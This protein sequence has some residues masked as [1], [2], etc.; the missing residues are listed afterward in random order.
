MSRHQRWKE[1]VGWKQSREQEQSDHGK[2][3]DEWHLLQCRSDE[4]RFQK[5]QEEV[6]QFRDLAERWKK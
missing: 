1:V 3:T 2:V 6:Q 4:E 5:R